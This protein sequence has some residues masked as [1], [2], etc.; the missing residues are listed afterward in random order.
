[1]RGADLGRHPRHR[2]E[3]TAL[4]AVLVIAAG[5]AAGWLVLMIRGSAAQPAARLLLQRVDA[6][7]CNAASTNPALSELCGLET[8]SS[9]EG[10]RGHAAA[11]RNAMGV[12]VVGHRVAVVATGPSGRPRVRPVCR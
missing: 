5:I 6:T 8:V 10:V 7:G 4:V 12:G 3:V 2:A 1:M 9:A 11:P